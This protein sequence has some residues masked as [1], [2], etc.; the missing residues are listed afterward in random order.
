MGSGGGKAVPVLLGLVDDVSDGRLGWTL[1]GSL[2]PSDA[3]PRLEK[4]SMDSLEVGAEAPNDGVMMDDD[5]RGIFVELVVRGAA[6]GG[7]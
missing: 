5:E 2:Y 6:G 4:K 7:L 3:I 1:M